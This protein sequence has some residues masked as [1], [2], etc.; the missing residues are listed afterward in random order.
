MYIPHY[1]PH[2]D[3][4][5][6]VTRNLIKPYPILQVVSFI[7]PAYLA[8]NRTP[9]SLDL[10]VS[11]ASRIVLFKTVGLFSKKVIVEGLA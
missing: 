2:D 7:R 6:N 4:Q 9:V 10:M 11:P 8:L 1:I 3:M 5:S